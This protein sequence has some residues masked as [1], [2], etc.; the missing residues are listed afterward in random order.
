VTQVDPHAEANY[1]I[2]KVAHEANRA[3]CETI[4]DNSQPPWNAA[5]EWQRESAINGVAYHRKNGLAAT[6]ERSHEN[7]LAE[8]EADG[9]T[10]GEE[11]DVNAKTHPCYRPYWELPADQRI[12][13]ALFA[14]VVRS[15]L[16]GEKERELEKFGAE[17]AN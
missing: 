5:P 4:G 12:K 13:E 1:A 2:A 3:Y 16:A 15:L 11:K 8:K 14:G 10:Y 9:W 17:V 6:P 7:W